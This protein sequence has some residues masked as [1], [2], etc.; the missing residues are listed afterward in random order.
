LDI[1]NDYR[2]VG[3]EEVRNKRFF[4]FA[5]TNFQNKKIETALMG[6]SGAWGK[7]F[8]EKPEAENLVALS[9]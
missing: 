8:H 4:L 3:V 2:H 9:L 7:L 5:T 6:Y 1:V